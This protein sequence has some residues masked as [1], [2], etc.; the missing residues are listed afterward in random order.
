MDKQVF[1]KPHKTSGFTL[2][3]LLVVIAII[4]ILIS[5]MLP[6]VQAAR[7]AAR[8]MTCTNN[9]KNIGLSFHNYHDALK[10]LPPGGIIAP[11]K[12]WNWY[13]PSWEM[14]V[15]PYIEQS[16]LYDG[17]AA[18]SYKSDPNIV[19][20]ACNAC[21]VK[22]DG[23]D[24]WPCRDYMRAQ[25]SVFVC[26]SQGTPSIAPEISVQP[27][28]SRYR[29]N[30]VVNFGPK[31]YNFRAAAWSPWPFEDFSWPEGSSNPDFVYRVSGVPFGLDTFTT[32][33]T[34]SDGLSNTIFLAEVTPSTSQPND[35][36]YG[37]TMLSIGA[38]YTAYH[39]PNSIG[40]DINELCWPA[41]AVGKGGK[42]TCTAQTAGN[43]LSQ[44]VTARSFH[45]GGVNVA[46]GDGSVNFV[47]DTISLHVWRSFATGAGSE[48]VT[49]P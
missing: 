14:R 28:W 4:G 40:P 45:T 48:S 10:G 9:M 47:S 3:E 6:A 39:T 2:V 33:A 46:M 13:S 42:A 36:R 27:E 41:G 49:L 21:D 23:T 31:D 1:Y 44:R 22:I 17:I 20:W 43:Q 16:A 35:T 5:L 38:G 30:Y 11:N 18:G 24:I 29:H 25:I 37:D 34:V 7:E 26:P 8:R 15:L 19:S 12:W 32:F